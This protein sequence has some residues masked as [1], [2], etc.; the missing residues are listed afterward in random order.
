MTQ[1]ITWQQLK[2]SPHSPLPEGDRIE[3]IEHEI[4]APYFELQLTTASDVALWKCATLAGGEVVEGISELWI[5]RIE[6]QQ[7]LH[8]PVS[9]Q[10]D[11]SQ[12]E[13]ASIFLGKGTA[14]GK[15][16]TSVYHIL[17]CRPAGTRVEL[18]WLSDGAE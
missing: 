11:A 3:V 1:T 13:T 12:L 14:G 18:K 7:D 5:A 8:G 4:D 6:L 16:P 17:D 2:D 10:A 15:R 9:F